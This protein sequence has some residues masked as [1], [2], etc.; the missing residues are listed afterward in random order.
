MNRVVYAALAPLTL[1]LAFA[2]IQDPVHTQTGPVSGAA[3]KDSTVRVYKGIPYAAPPVGDR[4]LPEN[5]L[6]RTFDFVR[7]KLLLRES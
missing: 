2:A 1:S 5:S 3:G 6:G 4:T 7:C